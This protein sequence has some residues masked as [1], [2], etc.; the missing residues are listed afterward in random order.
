MDDREAAILLYAE[1]IAEAQ[2]LGGALLDHDADK[3]RFRAALIAGLARSNDLSGIA[4][5]ADDLER[6]LTQRRDRPGVGVGASC[7]RL[8]RALDRLLADG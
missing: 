1:L 6:R 2:A 8:S 4:L 5:L 3:A 7:E